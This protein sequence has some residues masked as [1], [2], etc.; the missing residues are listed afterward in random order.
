[1]PSLQNKK[2]SKAE[3]AK[4]HK[5]DIENNRIAL[6]KLQEEAV[7]KARLGEVKRQADEEALAAQAAK[8]READKDNKIKIN[9]AA[10]ADLIAAGI[11][12]ADAK[13]VIRAIGRR[14]VRNISIQ[15]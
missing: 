14:E 3:A 4:Q 12:E 15:Y 10:L 13:T 7:E 2:Q 8:D 5:I 11:G 9:R 1:M 6:L